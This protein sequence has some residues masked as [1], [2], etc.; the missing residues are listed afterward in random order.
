MPVIELSTSIEAPVDRVFDL[1]RSIDLHTNST[2]STGER[3]IAGVTSGLIGQGQEVTWRAKHFGVWQSLT[4]RITDFERPGHFADS[5]L[6]GA[7]RRMEHHHY[8][9]PSGSGTRMRDVF[10]FESPLGFLGRIADFLF[11]TRY[12]RSFLIERNR[13]IKAAAESDDWKQYI[14]PI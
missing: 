1:A 14:R 6:R 7:F 12:M 9:E 5:M 13:V 2:S 8:F 3:A 11:L 10:T 4:V